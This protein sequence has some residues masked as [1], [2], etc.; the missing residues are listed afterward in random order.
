MNHLI[1]WAG[2]ALIALTISSAYLLDG[3]TEL[4]A[5]QATAE[6]TQDAIKSVAANANT[7]RAEALI[8][9]QLFAK[10]NP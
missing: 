7:A 3:P 8:D 9:S 6:S 1:N 4:D 5:A 10:S 2:A